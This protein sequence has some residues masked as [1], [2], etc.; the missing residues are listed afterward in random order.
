M[1]GVGVSVAHRVLG[2]PVL[3]FNIDLTIALISWKGSHQGEAAA[4]I[5]LLTAPTS[6]RE[7]L[8]LMT[9]QA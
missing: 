7:T 1:V 4:Y 6:I 9:T 2:L 8:Q 3:V 5:R